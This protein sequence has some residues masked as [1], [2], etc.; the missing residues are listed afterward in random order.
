MEVSE[1]SLLTLMVSVLGES[2]RG[3]DCNRSCA[4]YAKQ[5]TNALF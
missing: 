3:S 4:P 1:I 5:A 2:M